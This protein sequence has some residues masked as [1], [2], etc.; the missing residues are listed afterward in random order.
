MNARRPRL[1]WPDP[2]FPKLVEE[3][4]DVIQ[5]NL[6]PLAPSE[7]AP[8]RLPIVIDAVD[9]KRQS[10]LG[11]G[12]TLPPAFNA[13]DDAVMSNDIVDRFRY[14]ALL[15]FV[16]EPAN[17]ALSQQFEALLGRQLLQFSLRHAAS[18]FLS[19]LTH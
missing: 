4:R 15:V 9:L 19:P 14:G 12:L 8:S 10:G 18:V 5:R 1:W 6:A 11:H 17:V 13:E 16:H 7:D 2:V 3:P